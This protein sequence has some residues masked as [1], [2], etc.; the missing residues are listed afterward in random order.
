MTKTE[1]I[2]EIARER[3]VETMVQNIAHQSL[4]SNADLSDL[5]QMVYLILLEYDEDKLQDLWE[6]KQMRFFLARII[7]TQYRSSLSPFHITYRKFRCNVDE[8]VSRVCN[9]PCQNIIDVFS[10]IKVLQHED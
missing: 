7:V 1:I 10:S 3:M 6:H 5:C 9:E 4:N 8:N 2:E